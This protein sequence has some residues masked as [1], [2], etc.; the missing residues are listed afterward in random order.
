MTVVKHTTMNDEMKN[1]RKSKQ[2]KQ[3]GHKQGDMK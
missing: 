1:E 2:K 3:N